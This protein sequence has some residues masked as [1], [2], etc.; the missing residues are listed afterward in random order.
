V[1][2]VIADSERVGE[3]VMARMPYPIRWTN[4]KAIGLERDGVLVAGVL[5]ESMTTRDVNMHCAIADAGAL[6][7]EF[8][9]T[10]FHY[11]FEQCGLARVTGLVPSKNEKALKFD[12]DKLGFQVEGIIRKALPD[13]DNVI[14]LG[15]LREE[16][17]WL[18]GRR[19]LKR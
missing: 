17:R 12:I 10:C 2:R 15:M 5:Y 6:N 8:T 7:L 11:P 1:R 13:G 4:Y 14:V 3:W 18:K 19:A 16:C 9:Y